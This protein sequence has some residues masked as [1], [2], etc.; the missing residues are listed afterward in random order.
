MDKQ[1]YCP[2]CGKL[3]NIKKDEIIVERSKPP[4]LTYRY[5]CENCDYN[6]FIDYIDDMG[7]I[8]GK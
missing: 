8:D 2:K 7:V 6:T 4:I 1:L 5:E 3:L